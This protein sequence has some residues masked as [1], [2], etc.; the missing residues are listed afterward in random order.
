MRLQY[1]YCEAK[2]QVNAP[3]AAV[4]GCIIGHSLTGFCLS[5]SVMQVI[6]RKA[7]LP[8][9]LVAAEKLYSKHFNKSVGFEL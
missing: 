9:L 5:E 1:S 6:C 4:A 7:V 8:T 3:E 2:F